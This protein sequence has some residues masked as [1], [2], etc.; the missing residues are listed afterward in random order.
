MTRARAQ[1]VL[2]ACVLID[3]CLEDSTLLGLAAQHLGHVVVLSP[4]L[5]EV[6]QL[7]NAECE[8]L[9][10]LVVEPEVELVVEASSLRRGGLSFRD[11]LCLLFAKNHDATLYTNDKALL[12]AATADEI[13]A[14]WGLEILFELAAVGQLSASEALGA[15]QSIC[16]R[17]RFPTD[18][19]LEEFTRRL[20][21]H[22]S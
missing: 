5:E 21:R 19:L 11:R 2:D 9:G 15:A 10:L 13:S 1:L 18:A 6:G 3:F 14:Q 8:R 12:N 22:Q 4:I 20:A 17:S 16:G 7:D